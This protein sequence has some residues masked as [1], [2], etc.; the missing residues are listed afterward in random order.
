MLQL[1]TRLLLMFGKCRSNR[2]PISG[3]SG[4]PV[5]W[6]DSLES[7][8]D[9]RGGPGCQWASLLPPPGVEPVLTP[10]FK[11]CENCK[12]KAHVEQGKRAC[13]WCD[14]DR[15][16]HEAGPPPGTCVIV[17][18]LCLLPLVTIQEQ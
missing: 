15:P 11:G 6:L 8:A 13:C 16:T 7:S 1:T 10:T 14:G 5:S 12:M 9:P 2:L 3:E 18:F 17:P 4:V